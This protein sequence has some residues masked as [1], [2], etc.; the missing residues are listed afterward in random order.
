MLTKA[1]INVVV[2]KGAGE[3]ALF[4]DSAYEEAGAKVVAAGE[5]RRW[6]EAAEAVP[7][8]PL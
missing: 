3:S 4:P 6:L 1:G 8:T 5:V 2:E 7:R